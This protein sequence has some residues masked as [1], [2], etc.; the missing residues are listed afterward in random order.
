[1][2]YVALTRAMDELTVSFAHSRFYKGRRTMLIKSRFLSESGLTKG[3]LKI[4]KH[5]VY[6]KGSLVK[7][8]IFGMGRVEKVIK[9]GKD[10]KLTIN[11]GGAKRDI[12]SSFVEKV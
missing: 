2:G 1:M 10:S 6:K 3:S 4:E 7:H 12:L 11:F 5:S 9:V 8:K